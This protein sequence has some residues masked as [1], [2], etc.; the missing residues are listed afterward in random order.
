[1]NIINI[2]YL[3]FILFIISLYLFINTPF[4]KYKKEWLPKAIIFYVSFFLLV[5]SIFIS[6][7]LINKYI[8]PI[9]V[10]FNILILLFVTFL[11]K[12][13]LINLI[14]LFG[15][16]YLLYIFNYKDFEFKYGLLIKP[17][18]SWIYLYILTLTLYF[19]LSDYITFNAKINLILLLF[20]PLL[21][22]INEYFKH[23]YFTLFFAGMLWY[24]KSLF[25]K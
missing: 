7:K 21:F 19:L 24:N 5:I 9:A 22:P 13:T 2:D 20:Y 8:L 3:Y 18:I 16:I 10:Y 15:I 11:H 14:P 12:L 23:R 25:F 4:K 17:N 6:N 1:M